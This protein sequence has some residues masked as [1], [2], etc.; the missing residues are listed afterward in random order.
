MRSIVIFIIIAGFGVGALGA[1]QQE[2]PVSIE[3]MRIEPDPDDPTRMQ[4]FMDALTEDVPDEVDRRIQGL[5]P[6]SSCSRKL[7]PWVTRVSGVPETACVLLPVSAMSSGF[8]PFSRHGFL[9]C[10][11]S[12]SGRYE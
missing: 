10:R 8:A 3:G 1:P 2:P 11:P 4:V 7:C 9:R 6:P 5:L 12:L